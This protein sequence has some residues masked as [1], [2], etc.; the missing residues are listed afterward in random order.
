MHEEIKNPMGYEKELNILVKMS[1]PA[2]I[3][4]LVQSI[5]NL[6]DSY[7]VSH[8]GEKALR[9]VSLAF[10]IY[11]IMIGIGVGTGIG[12]N[13]Y[14]SR[15]MG[16]RNY[17]EV[18]NGVV[19][20]VVTLFISWIVFLGFRFL[21]IDK[22]YNMF[23]TDENVVSM[24]IDYLG[25]VSLFSIFLF[26]QILAEKVIQATG[27]MKIAMF[28]HLMSAIMNI[29]LDPILIHG[30]L[31]FPK[32]GVKGAAIATIFSQFMG[33]FFI[34][35]YMIRNRKKMGIR[36][37]GS[38]VRLYT[39]KQIYAVALPTIFINA[40]SSVM[41]IAVNRII[42]NITEI[43]ITVL[44][45]Y[46]RLQS[47]VYMPIFGL[48]QGF[49]PL[50]GFNYGAGNKDRIINLYKHAVGISLIF[51]M[52]GIFV[53]QA[54]PREL[55]M[56][57]NKEKTVVE[58]G[59]TA[60][61]ILSISVLF[62][63]VTIVNTVFFQGLGNGIYGLIITLIRQFIF[64]IPLTYVFSFIGLNYVWIAFPISELVG[65]ILSFYF[66]NKVMNN[67]VRC[68]STVFQEVE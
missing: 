13:S 57:F 56:I 48:G 66:Y 44:G 11:L 31:F 33:M 39:A 47:F 4:M 6:V 52:I 36:F 29:I 15:K 19:T 46:I 12:V 62:A 37:R 8:I 20:G 35:L 1:V 64:V 38:K 41:Q 28:S 10:P 24:G 26:Y 63:P 18:G 42:G 55:I 30:L 17:E 67:K 25:I 43:A 54:F 16:E 60:I 49:M 7:F 27:K 34:L 14:I 53:F 23:T 2:M 5:Y 21:F 51:T 50:V 68:I 32:M 45:L 9:A 61:R 65:L 40:F 59:L 22:F 58:L 3:S